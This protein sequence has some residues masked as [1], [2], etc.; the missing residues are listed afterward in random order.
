MVHCSSPSLFEPEAKPFLKWAGGKR[1][2]LKQI[3]PYF[4]PGLENG[5][6]KRYVEPFIGGGAIFFYI[7]Y[8]YHIDE[9]FISDINEELIL[10]YRTVQS[11][12]NDLIPLLA[13]LQESYLKSD[14]SQRKALFYRVRND[15]NTNLSSI[16]FLEFQPS[17]IERTAQLIFL[18]RTCFNGLFRI[19]SKGGFNVPFGKYKKPKICDA[20]NLHAVSKLLQKTKI[21][22][23]D[24]EGSNK[25]INADTFVYSDPPYRPISKTASFTS[26]SRYS[27]N[28]VSQ[29]R[30]ANFF[31][32]LD[33]QKVKLML[34]NSD[35][36]NINPDDNFFEELYTNFRINLV[37]ANRMINRDATKRGR[38]N[39]LII[40]NY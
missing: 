4:P 26:Y 6:I 5:Q 23:C 40:T 36:H 30:L 33:K 25:F 12:I 37:K 22:C 17:W 8:H 3:I 14:T 13:D 19:N 10:A 20:N 7:A 11:N 31:H 16:N 32:V 27:F 21:H 28:D 2:L 38:I 24:F 29:K 34:S 15:F 1:Q 39:E 18:N 35:P 9:L